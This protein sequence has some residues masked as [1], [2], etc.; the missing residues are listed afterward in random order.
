MIAGLLGGVGGAIAGLL[1]VAMQ[2]ARKDEKVAFEIKG[3][4]QELMHQRELDNHTHTAELNALK[5][6]IKAYFQRR[7]DNTVALRNDLVE[8]RNNLQGLGAVIVRDTDV[9]WTWRRHH[10]EPADYDN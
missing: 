10:E 8:V 2:Y 7:D 5:T 3:L 6:E 9:K 4:K 1:G